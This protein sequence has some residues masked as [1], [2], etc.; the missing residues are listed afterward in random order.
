MKD[1]IIFVKFTLNGI[2]CILAV[3]DLFLYSSLKKVFGK[4][5]YTSQP[6]YGKNSIVIKDVNHHSFYKA[7]YFYKKN[8]IVP[9]TD[10]ELLQIGI[11]IGLKK[12]EHLDNLL[13]GPPP[14]SPK[15]FIFPKKLIDCYNHIEICNLLNTISKFYKVS[16]DDILLTGGLLLFQTPL[17]YAH[18]I[19]VVIPVDSL[20][21]LNLII[22]SYTS[23]RIKLVKE[24][25]YIWPLRWYTE[26]KKIIC[27][28]FIYRGLLPP[29]IRVKYL[30][31]KILTTIKISDTKFS[32]FNMPI[33]ETEGPIDLLI[34]RS[35][36]LRGM[37][38]RKQILK[39]NCPL[40]EVVK[41]IYSGAIAGVITDPFTEIINIKDVLH[42]WTT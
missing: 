15:N 1:N 40:Y 30:N 23:F 37:L 13:C 22:K 5:M 42:E 28:F 29:V 33:I 8:K 16:N 25:G 35:T 11:K 10:K 24:Y 39:I 38:K 34:F 27:P 17:K 18:D 3:T 4:L 31:E 14:N 9:L 19:D 6:L 26:E 41:G 7:A 20:E 12:G 2:V 36:L 21:H 32:I